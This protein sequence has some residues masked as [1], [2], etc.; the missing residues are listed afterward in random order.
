M[1]GRPKG[2]GNRSTKRGF[3]AMKL[4]P[5]I[6]EELDRLL[7]S[8]WTYEE[9]LTWLKSVGQSISEP[10]LRSYHDFLTQQAE[11][12]RYTRLIWDRY[13]E[14]TEG[15]PLE[16]A[17]IAIVLNY[18]LDLL[19]KVQEI[20]PGKGFTVQD[21]R[22]TIQALTKVQTTK[23]QLEK[24]HL[25]IRERAR[26]TAVDVSQQAR[27]AGLPQDV[28]NDIRRKILGIGAFEK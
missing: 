4:P 14:N 5:E 1:A 9:V 17:L 27:E 28:C 12:E 24:W 16:E 21:A 2:A 15:K 6:K 7:Q 8:S 11:R 3:K 13:A 19:M 25:E 26:D 23:I 10:A 22:D 18:V 20:D